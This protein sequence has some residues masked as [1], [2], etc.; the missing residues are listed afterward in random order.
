M[1]SNLSENDLAYGNIYGELGSY[2]LY[3]G[4]LFSGRECLYPLGFESSVVSG[5]SAAN[6][7]LRG[8]KI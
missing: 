2:P 4:T 1:F 3:K 6:S 5:V 8:L 7:L